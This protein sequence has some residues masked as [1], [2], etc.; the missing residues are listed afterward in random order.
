M[1]RRQQA[2]ASEAAYNQGGHQ[3]AGRARLG[4]TR[5]Q[6]RQHLELRKREKSMWLIVLEA[7]GAMLVLVF[8]VWWTMFSGRRGGELPPDE[9]QPP[10]PSQAAQAPQDVGERGGTKKLE[11]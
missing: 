2:A 3:E 9:P 10:Q 4:H 8:V 5:H 7:M 6:H 11:G 1:H